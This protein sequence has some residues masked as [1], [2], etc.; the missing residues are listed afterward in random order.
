LT[1]WGCRAYVGGELSLFFM[2]SVPTTNDVNPSDAIDAA[3]ADAL[4]SKSKIG[5]RA[6]FRRALLGFGAA[7]GILGT[8]ACADDVKPTEISAPADDTASQNPFLTAEADTEIPNNPFA[9]TPK[10]TLQELADRAEADAAEAT[11]DAAAAMTDAEDAQER[12]AAVRAVKEAL[13]EE[14]S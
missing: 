2:S 13:T 9:V 3:R 5:A 1:K 8:P 14:S 11:A 7:I 4:A 6:G 12:A 10:P